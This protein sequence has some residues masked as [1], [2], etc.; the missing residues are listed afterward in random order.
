MDDAELRDYIET[1]YLQKQENAKASMTERKRCTADVFNGLRRMG[2]IEDL[3]EDKEITEILIN[4]K[5]NIFYEKGGRL[6]QYGRSFESDDELEAFAQMMIGVNNR[7]VNASKPIADGRLKDG[8]RVNVVLAPVSVS[9]TTVTI[10]R[11]SE[12]KMTMEKL[13][14]LGSLSEEI[15]QFLKDMVRAGYNIFISGGTGSGKTTFLNAL[16]DFIPEDERVITIEDSAE[17][18]LKNVQ[19]IVSLETRVAG[20]EGVEEISIRDLIRTSLRMRPDRIIV[21]ECRG[22]EALDMLQALNTGHQGSMSTGH[23]NSTQDSISRLEVMVATAGE[24]L[25]LDAIRGQIASGIDI[26]VHLG[27]LRDKSRKVLEVTEITGI[28]DGEIEMNKLFEFVENGFEDGK[29]CGIWEKVG[30][31]KQKE[32][33]K[34]AGLIRNTTS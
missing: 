11:F 2:I 25:P 8:S 33:L 18:Q 17:L 4:G 6:Y 32:K 1:L 14:A 10:R 5:D 13:K 15:E 29:V 26:L 23:A 16:S 22:P 34:L 21:G 12:N 31:L 9:G 19:N 27:R 30:E 28:R 3:M 24:K 20:A 7:M